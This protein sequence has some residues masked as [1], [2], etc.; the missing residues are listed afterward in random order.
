M[1]GAGPEVV[2][3]LLAENR[4]LKAALRRSSEAVRRRLEELCRL[5]AARRAERELL[6]G[7]AGQARVLVETLRR[8]RDDN[9][10]RLRRA[11]AQLSAPPD[12]PEEGSPQ[13]PPEG[14]PSPPS[15]PRSEDG[16]PPAAPPSPE[17]PP[18]DSLEQLRQRLAAVEAELAE[19]RAAAEARA[20]EA[21]RAAEA[22]LQALRRQ[23]E[24]DKASVKAQVTS[25]LGELQESQSRLESSRRER[26]QLEQRAQAAGARCRALEEAAL[27]HSVQLDQLRLQVS[28]L[29]AALRVERQGATEEKRKLVQ[30]QV[31]YHHLFQEYDAHIKA[32]LEGDKG[33][34]RQ[35]GELRAQLQQAEE[36]LAAKQ[37]LID[38]LKAEAEQQ[39]AALETVPVLQAQADIFKADFE[40]ERAARE[41]LHA[42][43][44]ALQDAVTQLQ[45]QLR[46]EAEGAARA[47]MEEMRNRHSELRPPAG[48]FGGP[49]RAPPPEEQPDFYCPKCQY[50]APDMDT[51]QIHV[52]DCIK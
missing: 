44:E 32:S 46:A 6:R 14:A 40:A 48:G 8:E 50:K 31:A 23:L 12:G 26:G 34:S 19:A 16:D 10:R 22:Q 51:L 3:R 7:R 42:Q 20:E 9:A 24:Q 30:L 25:L 11:L 18:R 13:P 41:Q 1:E 37:E 33:A 45:R 47:R 35:L 38:K 52:M 4:E 39:R 29:Q 27:G 49:P 21:A 17:E 36:A 5:Q 15:P 28:N 43:R 2:Q